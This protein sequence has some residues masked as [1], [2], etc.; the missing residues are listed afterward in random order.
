MT[1]QTIT[2]AQI[3]ADTETDWTDT[4]GFQQFEPKLGSLQALGAGVTADVAGAV[5]IENLGPVPITSDISL[6]GAVTVI[7]PGNTVLVAADPQAD[8]GATLAPYDGK[9]DFAGASGT[10]LAGQPLGPGIG[11]KQMVSVRCTSP[12]PRSPRC[13]SGSSEPRSRRKLSPHSRLSKP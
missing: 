2:Q 4:I 8:A 1:T 10:V 9:V 12:P 6:R 3:L 13:T 5:S 11:R 7:G